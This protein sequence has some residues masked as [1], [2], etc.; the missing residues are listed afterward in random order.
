MRVYGQAQ[1]TTF[2]ITYLDVNGNDYSTQIDSILIAVDKSMSSWLSSSIVSKINNGDTLVKP[3]SLF[4]TVFSRAQEISKITK[5]SFDITVG[6]L[7]NAYGFGPDK[8]QEID[9]NLIDS[10][11]QL[12]GYETVYIKNGFLKSK[13]HQKIDFN[14]IAQGYTVDLIAQ[15]LESK[16]IKDYLVEVGGEL[17]TKGNSAK[18]KPW[19][20][21]V[22]K[23]QE[24]LDSKN[25]FQVILNL[26][27]YALATS[28][29][30][31]KFKIDE[32]TGMKYVHTINPKTGYP[33]KSSLL[34]A[35]I[36]ADN[37]MDADAFAT[38]CM[39]KGLN[40]SKDLILSLEGVE[41][42]LVYSTDEGMV[43]TWTSPG[44]DNFV[45]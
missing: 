43:K 22:D 1:G 30:Y 34:S 24:N 13:L 12:V 28:G 33:I 36:I 14:A 23:P 35:S 9:S 17:I 41:A 42:Y 11:L 29:N 19:K 4:K 21:G 38:A 31:R 40:G 15:Y 45:D 32:K 25:R 5:G 2:A 37:C 26:S 27:G 39:V 6:P 20:V 10:L 18:D 16:S 44:F 8:A 3:D 7:V